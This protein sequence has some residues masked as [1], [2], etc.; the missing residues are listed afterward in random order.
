MLAVI[1]FPVPPNF[2]YSVDIWVMY[3]GNRSEREIIN[4]RFRLSDIEDRP[5]FVSDNR[6][7]L[8]IVASTVILRFAL[9]LRHSF[10]LN[11]SERTA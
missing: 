1:V 9:F 10:R 3:A 7:L 4:R 8:D 5:R 11:D 2:V 6:T